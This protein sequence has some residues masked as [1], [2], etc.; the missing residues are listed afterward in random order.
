MGK[1]CRTLGAY[2]HKALRSH[3][4]RA[5]KVR[6]DE[7]QGALNLGFAAP[8]VSSIDENDNGY[9]S[10]FVE[11]WVYS[12]KS[13]HLHAPK[14]SGFGGRLA[15]ASCGDVLYFWLQDDGISIV[16]NGVFLGTVFSEI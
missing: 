13:G 16:K 6:I 9:R 15:A 5:F 11:A 7:M 10:G 1:Y 2:E 12:C 4:V 14:D 8:N 3:P